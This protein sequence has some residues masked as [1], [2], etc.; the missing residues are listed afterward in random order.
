MNLSNFQRIALIISL[1][2]IL[3][4]MA[5]FLGRNLIRDTIR[6]VRAERL[7]EKAQVAFEEERW[8]VA[9]RQGQAAH[10]LSP[11]DTAIQLLV[12]QAT[13]KE[14][15]FGTLSWWKMLLDEP[16]LPVEDLKLLTRILLRSGYTDDAQLFINRLVGL[17]PE[18]RETQQLWL[19]LLNL[20]KRYGKAR[21]FAGELVRGGTEDW[22]I[23]RFYLN[24]ESQ[25]T[26]AQGQ[27]EAIAHLREL[28]EEGGALALNAARELA[29]NS[30]AGPD[31]RLLAAAYLGENAA[32][33]VDLLL[34]RS[35]EVRE[36]VT[37]RASLDPLLEGI[38]EE[39]GPGGLSEL[40]NWSRFMG[41]QGWFLDNV[42]FEAFLE[43]EGSPATYLRLLLSEN[44]F[45]E[46]LAL[47]EGALADTESGIT[48]TLIYYRASALEQLGQ[49]EEAEAALTTALQV[50]D[51]EAASGMENSLMQDNRWPL[52]I[53][54]YESLLDGNPDDPVILF[55]LLASAYYIGDQDKV[56]EVLDRIESG[57][58]DDQPGQASF[59]FYLR[60]IIEGPSPGLHERLEALLTEFS[61]VSDFRPVLGLSYLL[62]GNVEVARQFADGIPELDPAMPRFLRIAC[63]LLGRDQESY[64]LPGEFEFI[65]PRERYLISRYATGSN[66]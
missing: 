18:D 26:G 50:V 27:Q 5:L 59:V 56:G 57:A 24:L 35:I 51:P 25:L 34:A 52:L 38:L 12:A 33:D 30:A 31:D 22:G 11:E 58:Y 10:Y 55:K 15:S 13:L 46:L 29:L 49:A 20:Q 23:H 61:Q 2:G 3:S 7:Y 16:E 48:P 40:L 19:Q 9:A 63:I 6:E 32:D 8:D 1:I 43:N 41:S 28:V 66:P 62:R 4:L 47:T 53:V 54:L 14:R 17:A 36:G 65:L 37:S 44:R 60:L 21:E 42:T 39:P 45:Q 64:L